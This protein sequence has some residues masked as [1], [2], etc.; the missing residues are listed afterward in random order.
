VLG[1]LVGAPLFIGATILYVPYTLSDWVLRRPFFGWLPWR[2]I[3]VASIALSLPIML[4]FLVRFVREGHGTPMPMAP[5]RRL[6]VSGPFRWMRNPAYLAAL[7]TI[8][9]QGLLLGSVPV[10]LYAL[11]MA[12]VFHAF[13]VGYEE[14]TLRRTFG[15]DY[16]RYCH[17]VP[18]WLPRVPRNAR[19]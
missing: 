7:V 6:V 8:A 18:R 16:E 15:A 12:L 5:P 4:D 10:L 3:G 14:P 19:L 17:D 1:T 2:W 13:V 11:G 9:G